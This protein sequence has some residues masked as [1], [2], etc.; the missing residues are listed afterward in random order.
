MA[1]P[2][3]KVS[4]LFR[5]TP[6]LEIDTA[7]HV[8]T[9][10]SPWAARARSRPSPDGPH[11]HGR[12]VAGASADLEHTLAR[13]QIGRSDQRPYELRRGA[14][15]Y[16]RAVLP[17]RA[18]PEQRLPHTYPDTSGGQVGAR[19]ID[20]RRRHAKTAPAGPAGRPARTSLWTSTARCS[21]QG[22]WARSFHGRP[23]RMARG[24]SPTCSSFRTRPSTRRLC[25][26]A[27]RGA[28]RGRPF[29]GAATI[30]PATFCHTGR[31][32]SLTSVMWRLPCSCDARNAS[33]ARSGTASLRDH[34]ALTG[35]CLPP[36]EE[37]PSRLGGSRGVDS[38]GTG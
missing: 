25:C 3:N 9:Q 14:L 4:I 11:E 22:K 1:R 13:R 20:W 29:A 36:P 23:E 21:S 15:R 2:L 38:A 19:M 26:S 12:A 7:P 33:I 32:G 18:A 31:P 5:Q 37:A 30:H 24:R 17:H 10:R 28:P 34:A 6:G 16:L 8:S 27:R 35:T